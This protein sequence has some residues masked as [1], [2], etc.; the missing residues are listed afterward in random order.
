MRFV[1]TH[2]HLH[3][4]LGDLRRWAEMCQ[5]SARVGKS[6]ELEKLRGRSFYVYTQTLCKPGRRSSALQRGCSV[7]RFRAL[8]RR[9]LLGP[10]LGLSWGFL[11]VSWDGLGGVLEWVR[12]GPGEVLGSF[13]RILKIS[14]HKAAYG[15]DVEATWKRLGAVLGASW[16]RLGAVLAPSWGHVGPTWAILGHLRRT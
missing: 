6:N 13:W 16:A 12:E 4:C 15:W 3:W 14:F 1:V 9:P 11:G 5:R 10:L 2:R 7:S 8:F